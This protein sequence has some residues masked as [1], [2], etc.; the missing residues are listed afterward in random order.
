MIRTLTFFLR[1]G[2]KEISLPS[3]NNNDYLLTVDSKIYPEIKGLSLG[4]EVINDTWYIL[5]AG[6]YPY[7]INKKPAGRRALKAADV[8]SYRRAISDSS[9]PWIS[10]ITARGI[11][12]RHT[13]PG[14]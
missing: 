7:S 6:G 9:K 10:S 14:G 3:I 2:F 11:S 8:T 12:F 4:F 13:Q 1:S 5:N